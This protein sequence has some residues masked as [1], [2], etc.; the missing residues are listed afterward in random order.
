M[1][2]PHPK[3]QALS[4]TYEWKGILWHAQNHSMVESHHSYD[5]KLIIKCKRYACTFRV[6][7]PSALT[8]M[9]SHQ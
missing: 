3:L 4:H 6:A 8:S 9:E 5:A 1:H 2:L 7:E